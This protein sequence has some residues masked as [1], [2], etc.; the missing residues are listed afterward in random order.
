MKFYLK[1]GVP[2]WDE[3]RNWGDYHYARA[4]QR[5]L[6]E[7]GH[8]AVVQI[9][10]EWNLADDHDSDVTIHL[11]GLSRYRVKKG[12][13]NVLWIISHPEKALSLNLS[14]YDLV[15]SA[16]RDLAAYLNGR[17]RPPVVELLQFADTY[18]MYPDF[19][20]DK[21]SEILFIG[22]SRK[23]FRAIVQDILSCS[24]K[25]QIWGSNWEMFLPEEQICGTY[26]PYET[27]RHLYSSCSILLNDHWDDM[28]KWNMVNNRV[29]DALAC[30]TLLV[31][32]YVAEIEKLFGESVV[33]YRDRED[34]CRK[35]DRYLADSARREQLVE[36]GYAKI[37]ENHGVLK[38]MEE[39][40]AKLAL[41][42]P[43]KRH[44]I[45]SWV[46]GLSGM[47]RRS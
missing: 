42:R 23:V 28:R 36:H 22:N 41:A 2:K 19:Q 9:L 31:S 1:I 25:L 12:P 45:F 4:M 20:P 11:M 44:T 38:R 14:Q 16:S 15:F 26:Y 40:L 35:I 18:H 6:E 32:D 33:M 10:P 29:F 7:L 21:T 46:R 34:L 39:L 43:E 5:A 13:L 3:A 47:F 27:V 24:R 8:Q 17:V 30:K 37:V